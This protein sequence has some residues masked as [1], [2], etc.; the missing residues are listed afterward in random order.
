[1]DEAY[2]NHPSLASSQPLQLIIYLYLVPEMY[3]IDNIMWRSLGDLE[4][5]AEIYVNLNEFLL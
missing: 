1:M 4:K 5:M 2:T 3:R